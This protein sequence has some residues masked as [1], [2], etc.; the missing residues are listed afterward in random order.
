MAE[1]TR[2]SSQQVFFFVTQII[3]AHRDEILSHENDVTITTFRSVDTI[4]INTIT[5]NKNELC[6]MY[7][8]LFEPTQ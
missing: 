6:L 8:M 5:S 1:G 7:N 2:T 4:K 3:I